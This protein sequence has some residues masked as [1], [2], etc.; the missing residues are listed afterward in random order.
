MCRMTAPD[1]RLQRIGA[2]VRDRLE[3]L[4]ESPE[5]VAARAQVGMNT[6]RRLIA[7]E[8]MPRASTLRA[9]SD[10]LGWPSTALIEIGDGRLDPEK[11]AY[12]PPPTS[13]EDVFGEPIARLSIPG[14]R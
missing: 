9:I 6:I 3:R 14:V 10:A 4:G 13:M 12:L 11:L 1:E 8:N 7:G 5:R 2:A